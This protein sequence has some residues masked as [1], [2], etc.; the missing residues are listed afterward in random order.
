MPQIPK[1]DYIEQMN[2]TNGERVAYI[3]SRLARF[4]GRLDPE[5]TGRLIIELPVHKGI[6]G[7]VE[8][9]EQDKQA[10]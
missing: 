4:I 8:V 6:V 5:F 10:E 2:R 1:P 3:R 9:S 7:R